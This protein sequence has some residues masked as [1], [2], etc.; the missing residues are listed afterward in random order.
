MIVFIVINQG[1]LI[2]WNTIWLCH[3]CVSWQ[4]RSHCSWHFIRLIF[5]NEVTHSFWQP[6]YFYVYLLKNVKLI[7]SKARIP[8]SMLLSEETWFINL[9]PVD[10]KTETKTMSMRICHIKT[11]SLDH[12]TIII[13]INLCFVFSCWIKVFCK[14][15]KHRFYFEFFYLSFVLTF[16][17]RKFVNNVSALL[18]YY[19]LIRKHLTNTVPAGL[20]VELIK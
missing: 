3:Q 1:R 8:C 4:Y 11:M 7:W 6:D 20:F 9:S 18:C 10:L 17:E 16:V 13:K 19:V 2:D 12:T 14:L 5:T 15:S